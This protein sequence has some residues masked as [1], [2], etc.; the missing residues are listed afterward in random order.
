MAGIADLHRTAKGEAPQC[1]PYPISGNV[2]PRI[3]V[4]GDDG[5]T[6]EETKMIMETRKI[7]HAPDMKITATT[8]RV[9]VEIG[10]SESINLTFEKPF[11]L[12]EVRSILKNAPGVIL[13]DDPASDLYPTPR[14]AAGTD[15]VY[16]GRI[17]RDFSEKNS[18]NIWVVADNVRK[19]AATN[20]V[21]IAELLVNS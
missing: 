19:G 2:I 17:R 21:Q 10:H 16:V 4:F 12:D 13:M 14:H 1:F 8:V 3:D 20:A 5:Y 15:E 9:P 6:G 7:L 11:E 18:L